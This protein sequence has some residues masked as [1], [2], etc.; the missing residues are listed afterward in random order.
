MVGGVSSIAVPKTVVEGNLSDTT[1]FDIMREI[2]L[3][4]MTGVLF[5]KRNSYLQ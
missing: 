4:K 5:Q 3:P 1:F 2:A